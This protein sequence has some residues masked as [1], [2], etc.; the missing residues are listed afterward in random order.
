MSSEEKRG[1]L[2]TSFFS[3]TIMASVLDTVCRFAG[4]KIDSTRI[5]LVKATCGRLLLLPLTVSLVI[6]LS[7]CFSEPLPQECSDFF[8][9]PASA[10]E[11][12]FANFDLDK[13]LRI[14]RC[15]MDLKPEVSYAPDIA[16]RGRAIIPYLLNRLNELHGAYS[17]QADKSRYAIILIFEYL[18]K[19][20]EI[21]DYAPVELAISKAISE[22]QSDSY[23][24]DAVASL[25]QIQISSPLSPTHLKAQN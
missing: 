10:R 4:E 24:E 8:T 21:D 22:M 14:Q 11:K 20:N 9:T 17:Y 16:A 25:G 19:S 3:M 12:E 2:K 7:S 1:W 6:S 18:A 5:L 23:K 15:G 13:Q